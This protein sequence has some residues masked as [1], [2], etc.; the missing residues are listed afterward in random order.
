MPNLFKAN[1]ALRQNKNINDL[2][3]VDVLLFLNNSFR[4]LS[5]SLVCSWVRQFLDFS[6]PKKHK[7][8]KNL[9]P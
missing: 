3:T 5:K 6:F 8:V 9:K 2:N 1:C 4:G 7:R